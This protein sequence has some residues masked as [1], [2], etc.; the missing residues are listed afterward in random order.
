[1]PLCEIAVYNQYSR[2]QIQLYQVKIRLLHYYS[3]LSSELRNISDSGEA[4]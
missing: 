3:H 1:M 2:V 4:G